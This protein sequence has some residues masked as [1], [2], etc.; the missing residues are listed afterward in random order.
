MAIFN[1]IRGN[2]RFIVWIFLALMMF[3]AYSQSQERKLDAQ[4]ILT[5]ETSQKQMSDTLKSVADALQENAKLMRD[6]QGM[7]IEAEKNRQKL[8][9]LKEK[10]GKQN[11]A[12]LEG[13]APVVIPDSVIERLQSVA[14][15][16]RKSGAA[17]SGVSSRV[18]GG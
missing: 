5:L 1:L 11:A 12:D 2:S 17:G 4:R 7:A 16:A 14:D 15:A 8:N 18:D 6:L 9:D 13:V 3:W 10:G